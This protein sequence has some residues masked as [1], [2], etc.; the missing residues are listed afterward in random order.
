MVFVPKPAPHYLGPAA[1]VC[2]EAPHGQGSVE[3]DAGKVAAQHLPK[4]LLEV[5]NLLSCE[6]RAV[7]PQVLSHVVYLHYFR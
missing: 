4:P 5:F 1:A 7:V 6:F 2:Y 3:V